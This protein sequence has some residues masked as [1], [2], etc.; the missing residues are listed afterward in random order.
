[1]FDSLVYSDPDDQRRALEFLEQASTTDFVRLP[2]IMSYM[3]LNS[4]RFSALS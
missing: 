3:Y 1:M 2:I 4:R